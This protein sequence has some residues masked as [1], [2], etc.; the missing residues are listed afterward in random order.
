METRSI[1]LQCRVEPV[2][3]HYYYHLINQTLPWNT[4]V[5]VFF[6]QSVHNN[7]KDNAEHREMSLVCC[8]VSQGNSSSGAAATLYDLPWPYIMIMW[9][10]CKWRPAEPLEAHTA[11]GQGTYAPNPS[12]NPQQN[13]QLNSNRHG[14]VIF[15]ISAL[16]FV[17]LKV[18]RDL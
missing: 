9:S 6:H 8:Y 2:C 14:N 12:K 16:K 1:G 7:R 11:G 15:D 5:A 13:D 10:R 18:T 17:W 3:R 4:R